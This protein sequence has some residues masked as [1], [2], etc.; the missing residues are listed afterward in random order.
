MFWSSQSAERN[1]VC[2]CGQYGK[3]QRSDM[4]LAELPRRKKPMCLSS[5]AWPQTQS[6]NT[7]RAAAAILTVLPCYVLAHQR[8]E[9]QSDRGVLCKEIVV[10][11]DRAHGNE[12]RETA[13]FSI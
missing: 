3:P 8:V 5:R 6:Q 2:T 13:T 7:R 9:P 11:A 4:R 10:C 1:V 12:S